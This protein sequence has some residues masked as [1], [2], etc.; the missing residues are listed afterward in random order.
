[1]H[2]IALETEMSLKKIISVESMLHENK[3]N[4]AWYSRLTEE[5]NVLIGMQLYIF[6]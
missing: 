5:K 1:M 2:V 3:I 6:P 4:V